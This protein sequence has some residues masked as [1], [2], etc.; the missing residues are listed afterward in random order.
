[1]EPRQFQVFPASNDS[2]YFQVFVFKTKEEMWQFGMKQYF[3]D[4]TDYDAM[5]IPITRIKFQGDEEIVVPEIGVVLFHENAINIEA[6]THESVH[7][8][9]SY[10][11][12]KNQLKLS[13][14]IDEGE[15]RLAYCIGICAEQIF[16]VLVNS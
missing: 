4:K 5:T 12:A 7:V 2:L 8:A 16:N 6:I 3:K 15:E 13:D 9:T 14:E 10:L 1:M 11:R